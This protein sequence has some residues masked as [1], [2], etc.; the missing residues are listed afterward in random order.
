MRLQ[1]SWAKPNARVTAIDSEL[2]RDPKP[3]KE[4]KSVAASALTNAPDKRTKK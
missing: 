2:L 3:S 4:V 1:S